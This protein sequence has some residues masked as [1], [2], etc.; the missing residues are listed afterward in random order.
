M[1]IVV[2]VKVGKILDVIFFVE[3][4]VL[5]I[6]VID[7]SDVIGLWINVDVIECLML[8]GCEDEIVWFFKE[9]LV[10]YVGEIRYEEF[11]GRI[12]GVRFDIVVLFLLFEWF[13]EI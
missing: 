3:K 9:S 4:D 2:S 10:E 5:I 12:D 6:D 11:L 13:D 8:L 7:V 1:V